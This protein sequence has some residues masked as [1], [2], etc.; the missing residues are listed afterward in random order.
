MQIVREVIVQDDSEPEI[1]LLGSDINIGIG[2]SFSEPGYQ[3]F[4]DVDG[5]ITSSVQIKIYKKE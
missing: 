1:E 4:D 5:V 2:E 3:A